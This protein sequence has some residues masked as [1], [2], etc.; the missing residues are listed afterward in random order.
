MMKNRNETALPSGYYASLT[1]MPR[2]MVTIPHAH[3]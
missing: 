3:R 1:T 2:T